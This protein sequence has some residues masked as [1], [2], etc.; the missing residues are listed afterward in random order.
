MALPTT[1][2]FGALVIYLEDPATPGVFTAPCGFTEKSFTIER[3]LTDVV[4]PDCA[5]VDAPAW[6]GREVRSLTWSVTGSGV[7]ALEA[8]PTWRE[9]AESTAAYN[10]R[11]EITSAAGAGGGYYTGKAHIASFE[12]S[13]ALGEK[14]QISVDIQSDE[15]PVWTAF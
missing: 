5:N 8:L 2:K 15:A 6:V 3:D 7:L 9:F 10:V 4:V 1:R 12:V 13:G 14:L 11:V